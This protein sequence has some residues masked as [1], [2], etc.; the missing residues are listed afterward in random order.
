MARYSWTNITS[1]TKISS[2]I[3]TEL[4]NNTATLRSD[5]KAG[6][7][8]GNFPTIPTTNLSKDATAVP[9][10]IIKLYQNIDSLDTLVTCSSNKDGNYPT[11]NGSQKDGNNSDHRGSNNGGQYNSDCS[12]HRGSVESSDWDYCDSNN[13]TYHDSEVYGECLNCS[14]DGDLIGYA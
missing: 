11:N 7:D 1:N 14:Y 12:S 10:S 9:N 8:P 2:S 13:N 3:I 6:S 5:I 4:I